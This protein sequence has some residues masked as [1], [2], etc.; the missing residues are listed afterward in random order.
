MWERALHSRTLHTMHTH[1]TEFCPVFPKRF[2]QRTY[3]ELILRIV[4]L[5][6]ELYS[7]NTFTNIHAV[8]IKMK[9]RVSMSHGKEGSSKKKRID[10]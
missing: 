5:Q 3:V 4:P 9:S 6:P 7:M 2:R 1:K 10:S 8:S